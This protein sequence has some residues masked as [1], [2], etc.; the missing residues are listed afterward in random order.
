MDVRCTQCGADVAIAAD[1]TVLQC[2]FCSTALLVEAGETVFREVMLATVRA[3]EA[4]DHL[5]RFMAGRETVA[6]LDKHARIGQPQLVYFPFWAFRVADASGERVVLEPAAPSSL[7]GL[8][9]MTLPPGEAKSWS[10]ELTGDAPMLEVEIPMATAR[11]WLD[12]RLGKPAVR[13]VMLFHIP[14]YR[15]SYSY[16]NRAYRAAVEAVSGR[17]LPADFPAKAEAPFVAVAGLALAV[18]G[19]EGLVISNLFA[20]AV[21]YGISA[22]PIFALAWWISRKV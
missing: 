12:E 8:Q 2:P 15:F 21:V 16:K 7:Q 18:F 17:V 9:G 6:G 4:A 22:V 19:I 1:Q 13:R 10:E 20:K 14:F 3:H 11:T 5:K